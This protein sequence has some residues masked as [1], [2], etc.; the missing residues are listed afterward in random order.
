MKHLLFSQNDDIIIDWFDKYDKKVILMT[1]VDFLTN[2][3]TVV[4][5][6]CKEYSK[7]DLKR[8]S[9]YNI[10]NLYGINPKTNKPSLIINK[11]GKKY[12]R[13]LTNY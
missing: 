12:Y 1:I 13:T 7:N 3:P 6:H 2:N 4:V 11:N 8:Y 5:E 9:G 10:I